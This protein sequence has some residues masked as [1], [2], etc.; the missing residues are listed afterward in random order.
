VLPEIIDPISLLGMWGGDCQ[1][2]HA[3]ALTVEQAVDQ[4]KGF[5]DRSSRRT[6]QGCR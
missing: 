5:L 3:V 1:N 6:Q 2:R 4:M